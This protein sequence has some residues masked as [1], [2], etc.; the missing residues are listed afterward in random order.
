MLNS[1]TKQKKLTSV[2]F[3]A[4]ALTKYG[5]CGLHVKMICK[6]LVQPIYTIIFLPHLWWDLAMQIWVFFVI[7]TSLKNNIFEVCG[8]STIT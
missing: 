1:H 8:L 7:I 3:F 4:F 5:Q 2:L 6:G